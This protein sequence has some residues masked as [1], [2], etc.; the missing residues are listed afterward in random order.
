VVAGVAVKSS[1]LMFQRW[2][3]AARSSYVELRQRPP[4]AL[5]AGCNFRGRY[6]RVPT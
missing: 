1:R 2:P 6:N 5:V 3:R 4:E